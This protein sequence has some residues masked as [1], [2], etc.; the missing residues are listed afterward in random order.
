MHVKESAVVNHPVQKVFDYVSSPVNY[1]E[2]VG[3]YVDVHDIQPSTPGETK[4]GDKFTA[5]SLSWAVG[6]ILPLR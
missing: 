4:E 2:W 1:P 6:L 5:S 3:P